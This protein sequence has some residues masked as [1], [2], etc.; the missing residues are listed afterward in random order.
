ML[1]DAKG[2]DWPLTRKFG[3]D[4]KMAA[5][6]L[7][8]ARSLGLRPRGVSFHVGSQQTQPL[9]WQ[10]AIAAAAGIFHACASFNLDLAFLNVGGGL[11]A[12]YR[13]PIPPLATYAEIIEAALRKHFG[14]AQ[15]R[16]SPSHRQAN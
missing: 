7:A 8:H 10:A 1:V 12:Q 13:T 5:D 16:L 3:C 15:P 11:P 2:A 9:Q 14:G 4:A 6:L